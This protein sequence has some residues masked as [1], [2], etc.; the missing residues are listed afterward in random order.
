[1]KK[2]LLSFALLGVVACQQNK[3]GYVDNE[4]IINDYQAKIDVEAKFKKKA[5][6]LGKK[7]DSLRQAFQLEATAFQTKAQSMP[8][9]KAQEEYAVLQQ[10]SQFLSQQIQQEEQQL[11]L[12]SQTEMDSIISN[13]KDEIKKYGEANKY[14]FILGGGDNGSVLYGTEGDEITESILKILN[15]NY[16]K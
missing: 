7:T 11:Q 3:I 4:E 5:E 15:N 12:A 8:Q 6:A 16:K 2:L 14:T 10:R 1:M 9:K 13:V